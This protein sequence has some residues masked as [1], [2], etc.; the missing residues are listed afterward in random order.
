MTRWQIFHVDV[1]VSCTTRSREAGA[2]AE[3]AAFNKV[4]K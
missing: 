4:V 1:A 3:L 2:A